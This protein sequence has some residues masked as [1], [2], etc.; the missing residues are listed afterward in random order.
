[1]NYGL[2]KISKKRKFESHAEPCPET[3]NVILNLFQDQG[4]RFQHLIHKTQIR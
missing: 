2:I 4:L 3:S 1:M